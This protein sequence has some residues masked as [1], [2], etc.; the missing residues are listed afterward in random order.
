[1]LT[2]PYEQALER[3]RAEYREM[4]DMRLTLEQVQRLSGVDREV[5]ERVLE[6]L[7]RAKFISQGRDGNYARYREGDPSRLRPTSS[8]VA[9]GAARAARR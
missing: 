8:S 5:C 3:I 1:M 6:D 4:P 7:V 2:T 9:Q